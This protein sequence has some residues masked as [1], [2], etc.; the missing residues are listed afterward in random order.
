MIFPLLFVLLS[1]CY[2]IQSWAK[3]DTRYNSDLSEEEVYQIKRREYLKK[4]LKNPKDLDALG[5]LQE[6]SQKNKMQKD[7]EGSG[8]TSDFENI[9]VEKLRSLSPEQIQEMLNQLNQKNALVPQNEKVPNI[10]QMESNLD[11]TLQKL[12]NSQNL[13]GNSE[14]K[15]T[16]DMKNLVYASLRTFQNYSEKDLKKLIL[17]RSEGSQLHKIFLKCDKCLTFSA[18]YL[19]DKEAFPKIA[20]IPGQ[21]KLLTYFL[22][23]NIILFILKFFIKRRDNKK[24]F[25]WQQ[26]FVA[27]LRRSFLI[28]VGRFAL[29]IY[30]LGPFFKPSYDVFKSVFLN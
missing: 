12:M 18:R 16:Q 25:R 7:S 14:T 24:Y 9:D 13:L 5:K 17:E 8:E 3:Q 26:K 6:H 4:Y 11:Q 27:S 30:F 29:F 10:K 19:K 21:R 20:E 28:V 22:I 15:G 23:A 2:P 1:A